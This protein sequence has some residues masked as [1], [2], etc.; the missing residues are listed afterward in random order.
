MALQG[1]ETLT[2]QEFLLFHF[3]SPSGLNRPMFTYNKQ[4]CDCSSTQQREVN[5][6]AKENA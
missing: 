5:T 2:L 3:A 4:S 1:R 6:K